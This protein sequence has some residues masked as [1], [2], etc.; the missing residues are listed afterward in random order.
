MTKQLTTFSGKK[1]A[2]EEDEAENVK[3]MWA[4]GSSLQIEL[5][6]GECVN[7]KGIES[8]GEVDT[9]AYFLGNLMNKQRTKVFHCGEWKVFSGKKEDI[10]EVPIFENKQLRLNK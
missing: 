4:D 9:E 2:L 1:I 3:K 7:P 5:R 6:N 10:K 8:I